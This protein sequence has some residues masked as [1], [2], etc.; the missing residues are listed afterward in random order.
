MRAEI[1]AIGWAR[2]NEMRK[3]FAFVALL[4]LLSSAWA[5]GETN[6]TDAG[7]GGNSANATLPA[8]GPENATTLLAI[9]SFESSASGAANCYKLSAN[10]IDPRISLPLTVR[11]VEISP[12][13]AELDVARDDFGMFVSSICITENTTVGLF[14]YNRYDSANQT[15]TLEFSQPAVPNSTRAQPAPAGNGKSAGGTIS[16]GQQQSP[17][18]LIVAVIIAA[19]LGI[20]A[21]IIIRKKYAG[22]GNVAERV[23]RPVVVYVR[24]MAEQM[25]RRKTA[26]PIPPF[27]PVGQ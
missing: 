26:P 9:N 4:V 22:Q 8:G 7:L 2:G 17:I 11:M 25:G 15:I 24:K 16:E 3:I 21:F 14:A 19:L 5:A 13:N 18:F 12:R 1:A 10:V 23:L 20:G 27:P 6:I